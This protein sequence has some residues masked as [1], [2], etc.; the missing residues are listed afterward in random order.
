MINN[1]CYISYLSNRTV[2]MICKSNNIPITEQNKT[3]H[4]TLKVDV[5]DLPEFISA[6][7]RKEY[8]VEFI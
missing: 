6:M 4:K 3:G 8:V 2:K 5:D 1:E 7:T